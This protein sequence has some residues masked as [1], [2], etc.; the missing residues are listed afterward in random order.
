MLCTV[1]WLSRPQAR[2]HLCH[3]KEHV[4]IRPQSSNTLQQKMNIK[5]TPQFYLTC[6]LKC[7]MRK[8]VKS[9]R[10][11]SRRDGDDDNVSE[12]GERREEVDT[13]QSCFGY[14]GIRSLL[15]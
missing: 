3:E 14:K 10:R 1:L 4:F 5:T 15:T 9:T 2:E 8:C 13:G 7:I 11:R 6:Q 12:R